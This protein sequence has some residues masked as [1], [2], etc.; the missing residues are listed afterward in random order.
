MIVDRSSAMEELVERRV[1]S[2]NSV[3]SSDAVPSV[4]TSCWVIAHSR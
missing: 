2:A 4:L 3:A 1:L